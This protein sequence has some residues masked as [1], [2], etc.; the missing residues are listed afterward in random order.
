M[1]GLYFRNRRRS[2]RPIEV[3]AGVA[4]RLGGVRFRE[5]LELG[6]ENVARPRRLLVRERRRL[7]AFGRRSIVN[8]FSH[9]INLQT[10]AR[11]TPPGTQYSDYIKTSPPRPQG[12]AQFVASSPPK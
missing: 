5:A 12:S 3:A 9:L 8:Y 7:R 10:P 11:A 4:E 1:P 6:E 2:L